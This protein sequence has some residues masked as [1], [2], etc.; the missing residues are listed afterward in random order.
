MSK[1][2]L[3]TN[4]VME[5]LEYIRDNHSDYIKKH[6][7]HNEDSPIV[8]EIDRNKITASYIRDVTL[9]FGNSELQEIMTTIAYYTNNIFRCGCTFVIG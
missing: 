5:F 7:R 2:R 4:E 6:Q 1:E 3:H 9:C 8:Y